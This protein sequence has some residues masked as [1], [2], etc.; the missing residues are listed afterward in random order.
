[1]ITPVLAEVNGPVEIAIKV[2]IYCA[3]STPSALTWIL[4]RLA[5]SLLKWQISLRFINPGQAVNSSGQ[6]F[7]NILQ[8]F[9]ALNIIRNAITP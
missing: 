8:L 5:L 4:A 6:G 3:C 9:S 1:M 7:A 2:S